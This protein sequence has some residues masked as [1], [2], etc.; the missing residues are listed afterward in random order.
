[1][2]NH[3]VYK[4]RRRSQSA[5]QWINLKA[6]ASRV[7]PFGHAPSSAAE[8]AADSALHMVCR[9]AARPAAAGGGG[10]CHRAAQV[11]TLWPPVRAVRVM[12]RAASSLQH[13]VAG[14]RDEVPRR[15]TRLTVAAVHA[16][17]RT[18]P[19]VVIL[20]CL[21]RARGGCRGTVFIALGAGS[22]RFRVRV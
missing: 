3:T 1:M 21:Q 16:A 5:K 22:A 8:A 17:A 4:S 2:K 13:A 15:V 6:L 19:I 14:P 18:A 7:E 12:R 20:W 11:G 10:C 9:L